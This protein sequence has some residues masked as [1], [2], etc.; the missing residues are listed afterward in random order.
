MWSSDSE[1]ENELVAIRK[2][3]IYGGKMT[4]REIEVSYGYN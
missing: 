4:Y 2:Q 1:D 3:I